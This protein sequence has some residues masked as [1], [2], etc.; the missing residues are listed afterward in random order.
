MS[1]P[2]VSPD[3]ERAT[4]LPEQWKELEPLVDAVLDAAPADRSA[5]I[6]QLSGGDAAKHAALS[7]MIAECDATTPLFY[8]PAPERFAQLLD[9]APEQQLPEIL[10]DRYRIEREL[11]R[12]GMARVFLALDMKHNRPVAVKV[13]RP[14][15][16]ASL[17]RERFLR[18]IAIAA[19]LRHPNI[20]PLYDS[21]D[22][23]GV[24]YVVMPYE[25][26]LSLR[27]RLARGTALPA[28][29]YVSVLSDVA[30]ALSY[31]HD[32]GVVHR[33]VKP[34]NVMLS[35]GAA[36]VTDFGIAK[37]VSVAQGDSTGATTTLTQTGSG[38]GTPTYM[39]PGQ[40]VGDPGT[41]HRADIYAFGCVAYELI[42]GL[43][44]FHDLPM[45]Q[46]VAAHVALLQVPI[47]EV[48]ADVSERLA[49]L[50]MRSVSRKIR[51]TGRRPQRRCWMCSR[52]RK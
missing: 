11:G 41:D 32:Q 1:I 38:I 17:G 21:G 49:A 43:P 50:V 31:A 51:R 34:D 44:P 6:A 9:E 20:V 24:L 4:P 29:E 19:R 18:E 16:A 10:G 15:L 30:R 2:P 52:V 33:D 13:I 42:T 35:G 28:S 47:R 48:Q 25:D 12:G 26:G 36:V 27:Q 37:A 40:A 3:E 7:R 14:E 46:L 39:A 23:D 22:T 5:L 8:T 45:H